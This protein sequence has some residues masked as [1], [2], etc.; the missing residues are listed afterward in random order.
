MFPWEYT[1]Q[2]G[3]LK[4]RVRR[5]VSWNEG[6]KEIQEARRFGVMELLGRDGGWLPLG[7]RLSFHPSDTDYLSFTL[8]N[9]F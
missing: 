6:S 9:G 4:F 8:L 7:I 2:I 1:A 5:P 3:D